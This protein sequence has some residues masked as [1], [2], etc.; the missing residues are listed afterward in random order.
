[1]ENTLQ[2][3]IKNKAGRPK[4]NDDSAKIWA[5]EEHRRK[6]N[7]DY[8][9]IR[10]AKIGISKCDECGYE[11]ATNYMKKHKNTKYHLQFIERNKTTST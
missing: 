9:L 10:K 4:K 3:K 11:C 7:N 8:Y 2:P 5:D 1:M 6:Y